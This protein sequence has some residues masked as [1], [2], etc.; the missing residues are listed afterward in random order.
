M[1]LY[2][3][4]RKD[5]ESHLLSKTRL[6]LDLTCTTWKEKTGKFEQTLKET[7]EKLEQT[8]KE[9]TGKL[10]QTFKETTGKLEQTVN[11]LEKQV[12]ELRAANS[13]LSTKVEA[14]E[15]E[16]MRLTNDSPTFVWKTKSISEILKQAING[17]I[18]ARYSEPF[19][20]GKRGYTLRVC[21][22]PDG[23]QTNKNRYLSVYVVIMKGDYDAI[24]P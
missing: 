4:Q 2:Y 12:Q 23:D 21:I 14:Q 20:A 11:T 15:K 1:Y 24:L 3:I 8:L 18:T 17:S 16:I 22:K 10:E 9:T 7:T 5:V 6:H 19:Y 13:A